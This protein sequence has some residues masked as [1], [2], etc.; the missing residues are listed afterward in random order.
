MIISIVGLLF[1]MLLV[2]IPVFAI[3]YFNLGLVHRFVNCLIRMVI[4]V[5]LMALVVWGAVKLDSWIYD[6]VMMLLLTL[7]TSVLTLRRSRLRANVLLIPAFIGTF[8]GLVIMSFYG[9]ILILGDHNP[10]IAHVFIPFVG[11]IGGS[12]IDINGKSLQIYYSGLL[13]HGQLYNYL[14]GNGSTHSEAVRYFVRRSMQTCIITTGKKMS[15]LV[16]QTAPVLLFAMVMSGVDV[17]TAACFQILFYLMVIAASLIA[18]FVTLAIA[19][20]Y[21]FDEYE[22]LKPVSNLST[23]HARPRD[24]DSESLQQE[25]QPES[26]PLE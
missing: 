10:F 5:T 4:S 14:L 13:H 17:F 1:G 9:I 22:R 26:R 3:Y 23:N 6:V 11:I 19:R 7:L 24:I 15:R 2:A 21:S 12:M 18:L 16:F 8:A 20:R 25:E